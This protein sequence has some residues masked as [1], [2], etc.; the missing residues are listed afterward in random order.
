ME[1]DVGL[2]QAKLLSSAEAII[3]ALGEK[4]GIETIR[5]ILSGLSY[6]GDGSL[7]AFPL[8]D[9]DVNPESEAGVDFGYPN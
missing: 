8:D 4:T 2:L 1:G 9:E 6:V 7:Q 3:Q 5:D